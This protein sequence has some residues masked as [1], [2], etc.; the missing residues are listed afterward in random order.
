LAS[1]TI[2]D[3]FVQLGFRIYESQLRKM[4][5]AVTGI[6]GNV[7]ELAKSFAAAAL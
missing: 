6:K 7:G 2:A 3:F 5:D 1:S 4:K